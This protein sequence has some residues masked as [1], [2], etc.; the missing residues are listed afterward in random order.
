[1]SKVFANKPK[2]N[3]KESE[4]QT[5]KLK[6]KVNLFQLEGTVEQFVDKLSDLGV[7]ELGLQQ[8]ASFGLYENKFKCTEI[9]KL[10]S[11]EFSEKIMKSITC[12]FYE[13]TDE[14]KLL[15]ITH[16][17]IDAGE[18]LEKEVYWID[19]DDSREPAENSSWSEI[20]ENMD[21]FTDE[22]D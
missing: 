21:I 6:E 17:E 13:N 7:F 9:T 18:E 3:L 12:N 15:Y 1:M 8:G 22:G 19:A 11:D 20:L 4:D 10:S 2:G 5:A 14:I 16:I